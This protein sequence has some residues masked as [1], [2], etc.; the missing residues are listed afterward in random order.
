MIINAKGSTYVKME[1]TGKC[2]F[3]NNFPI[4]AYVSTVPGIVGTD[5]GYVDVTADWDFQLKVASA[6][7]G[8]W[9][10]ERK[11]WHIPET[12]KPQLHLT[13]SLLNIVQMI[14]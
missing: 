6:E 3:W 9:S 7:D 1:L 8:K 11:I 13:G 2:Q 4:D 5:A 12:G 10:V 14:E